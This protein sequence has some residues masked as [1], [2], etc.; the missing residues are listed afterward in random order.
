MVYRATFGATF[1]GW[2]YFW[3]MKHNAQHRLCNLGMPAT[4]RCY[5]T[6]ARHS[7]GHGPQHAPCV[8]TEAL[9]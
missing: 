4:K 1:Y 6:D 3:C 8:Y 7:Y 5:K 9:A 2:C